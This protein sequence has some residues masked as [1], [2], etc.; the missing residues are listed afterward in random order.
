MRVLLVDD[1]QLLRAGLRLLLEGASGIE[2]VGEARDGDEAVRLVGE[3]RPDVV[4]MDVRMPGTDGITAVR[5]LAARGDLARTAVIMLTAFDT[6]EFI[7]TALDAGA[8]GFLLKDTPPAQLVGAVQRAAAGETTIAPAVLA[9][10]VALAGERRRR[11]DDETT[12]RFARLTEREQ[13]VARALAQG[14]SNAE[15]GAG[16]GLGTATVKTHLINVFAKL[17]VTN[18]VQVALLVRDLDGG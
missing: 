11:V 4:L 6:D 5:T 8:A 15:I 17:A 2:V 12:T 18:R 7:L 10:L 1:E 13:Q 3:R 9:R 14:L 16:L